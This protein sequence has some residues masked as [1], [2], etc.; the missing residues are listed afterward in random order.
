MTVPITPINAGSAP[1]DKTGW[2]ARQSFVQVNANEA[3]IKVAIELLQGRHW[4]LDNAARTLALGE[5]IKSS[6]H[7][8]ITHTL[9]AVFVGVATAERDVWVWNADSADNVTLAPGSGDEIFLNG[10][11]Q[12]ADTTI[13]LTPAQI[14]FCSIRV[15]NASWDVI[16]FGALAD[17][18]VTYAKIQNIVDDERVLGRVSGADGIIEELT[19]IQVL[20]FLAITNGIGALTAGEVNQLENIGGTTITTADWIALAAL[21]GVNTGDEVVAS[22]T[23]VTTGSDA[24]KYLSPSALN[25]ATP[26]LAGIDFGSSGAAAD[27]LDEYEEGTWTPV[28]HDNSNSSGEGQTYDNQVGKYTKVGNICHFSCFLDVAGLGT[29]TTSEQARVAGL[30]FASVSTSNYRAGGGVGHGSGMSITAG[31]SVSWRMEASVSLMKLFN[32]D[33]G[34]GSSSL[35]ISELSASGTVSFSGVYEVA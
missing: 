35:P 10:V 3:A 15:D 8:G 30:P 13:T 32:S 29:L 18:S 4:T 2:K 6:I 5:R 27:I 21:V 14:A 31:T 24:T 19:Q 25:G 17:D 28:L 33:V 26:K 16:V 20:T 9:Q 22:T 23:E 7:G 12:G 1:G 34:T 11:G